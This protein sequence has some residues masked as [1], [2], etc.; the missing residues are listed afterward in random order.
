MVVWKEFETSADV[1]QVGDWLDVKGT[2][3]ADGTL[4]AQSGSIFVNIGR[5]DGV[6]ESISLNRLTMKHNKGIETIELSTR[7]EV[8]EAATQANVIGG[9]SSLTPGTHIGVV[10]LRLP[11][12]GFRATRIWR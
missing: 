8:V 12:G 5:R 1:I 11:D 2:P 3:Q 6:V 4:V 10:G 7:L 9:V